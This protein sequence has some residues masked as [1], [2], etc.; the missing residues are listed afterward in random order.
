MD[1]L[2]AV[3]EALNTRLTTDATLMALF[4]GGAVR[5]YYEWAEQDAAFPYLVISLDTGADEFMEQG[6]F[7]VNIWDSASEAD[8]ALSIRGR[9]RQLL[10]DYAFTAAEVGAARLGRPRLDQ[11][12]PDSEP[13]IWRREITFPIRFF[14]K[15]GV[16]A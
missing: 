8:R 14:D 10:Y 11:S 12:I 16:W 13:G 3:I 9:V 5:L 15:Q 6:D 2:Q 1:T 4:P 7:V